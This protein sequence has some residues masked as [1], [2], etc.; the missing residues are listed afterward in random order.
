[1]RIEK[2]F[3]PYCSRYQSC[4]FDMKGEP[5]CPPSTDRVTWGYVIFFSNKIK[6]TVFLLGYLQICPC[7]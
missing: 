5:L 2:V 4:Y 7:V 3:H 1:M 6:M